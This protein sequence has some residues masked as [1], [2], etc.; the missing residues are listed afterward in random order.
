MDKSQQSQ[1]V[2]VDANALRRVLAA[3]N[4]APHLIRELQFTRDRPPL[5]VGNPID[6]LIDQFNKWAEAQEKEND[7]QPGSD[8][9]G[10]A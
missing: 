6:L 3:F 8:R 4:G 5:F 2:S 10:P 7:D 1:M 9:S